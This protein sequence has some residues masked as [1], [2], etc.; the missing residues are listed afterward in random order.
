MKFTVCFVITHTYLCRLRVALASLRRFHPQVRAF[1]LA[2][3]DLGLYDAEADALTSF[4][5][6]KEVGFNPNDLLTLFEKYNGFEIACIMKA[7]IAQYALRT[8]TEPITFYL[9]ADL[10]FT[11]QLD[12]V[13]RQLAGHS[14]L[15][16]PHFVDVHAAEDPN[17]L[18][19]LLTTE[20]QVVATG[21]YNMGFFG[22][23]RSS[24][25]FKILDWWLRR[26]LFHCKKDLAYGFYDDQKWMDQAPVLFSGIRIDKNPGLNVGF[27]NLR[28]RELSLKNGRYMVHGLPLIFFHFSQF[29]PLQ[30]YKLAQHG[31]WRVSQLPHLGGL[32][33]TY[34]E[35]LLASGFNRRAF[36]PPGLTIRTI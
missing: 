15:L 18:A 11:S 12:P 33:E 21:L 22:V 3:D 36:E 30:P 23:R 27:W 16:T 31:P 29:N 1:V 34:R 19:E 20:A 26:S 4:V 5:G 8:A 13:V 32:V 35:A 10:F 9:D 6:F 17:L 7:K 14:F 28:E 2:I 25:G 24:E